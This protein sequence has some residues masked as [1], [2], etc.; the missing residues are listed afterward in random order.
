MIDTDADLAGLGRGADQ[1]HQAGTTHQ[2][3]ETN[4]DYEFIGLYPNVRSIPLIN[5][6]PRVPHLSSSNASNVISRPTN[7][8]H[9]RSPARMACGTT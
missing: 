4:G 2:S 3:L 7:H 6:C 5:L 9:G 1:L 8:F